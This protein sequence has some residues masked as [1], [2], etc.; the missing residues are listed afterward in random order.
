MNKSGEDIFGKK[1]QP[2]GVPVRRKNLCLNQWVFL[3]FM[4]V[5]MVVLTAGFSPAEL[6]AQEHQIEKAGIYKDIYPLISESDRYC[7]FFIWDGEIPQLRITGAEREYEREM[8]SDGDTV[9]INQGRNEGLERGQV[10]MI[11]QMRDDTRYSELMVQKTV[12]GYGLLAYRRGRL[13]IK[14]LGENKASAEI[15]KACGNI[16]VGDYLV[17]FQPLETVMGKDLGYDVS[18]FETQG[19]GGEIIFLETEFNQIGDG[20][21]ALINLGKEDNVD[22]GQQFIIFRQVKKGAPLKIFGNS[23]VID[24]QEKT[25]T[26]KVLSSRDAV[27]IGDQVAVNPKG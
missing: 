22:R 17:P 24:V 25:S 16:M 18:P 7:S 12:P 10:F 15:E 1:I 2:G 8:F 5:S 20:H 6:Y 27:E 13:R 4:V 21:L 23:V 9:Y 3:V 14:A 11:V 19:S 26:I